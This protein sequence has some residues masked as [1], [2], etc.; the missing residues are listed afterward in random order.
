MG[1]L[2][3]I[4]KLDSFTKVFEM[5]YYRNHARKYYFAKVIVQQNKEPFNPTILIA[6]RERGI[7]LREQT[8]FLA[9]LWEHFLDSP[10]H[11]ALRKIPGLR[12]AIRLLKKAKKQRS[13]AS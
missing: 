8:T 10:L 3:I 6:A 12:P 2:E 13:A 1:M 9:I 5:D 11:N 4:G 7:N